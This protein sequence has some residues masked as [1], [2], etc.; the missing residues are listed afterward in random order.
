MIP[1]AATIMPTTVTYTNH[2]SPDKSKLPYVLLI[3]YPIHFI[4][5]PPL[6]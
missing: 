1:Y 4:L 5:L 3:A 2:F 6:F